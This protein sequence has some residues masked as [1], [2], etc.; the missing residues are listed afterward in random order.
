MRTPE[1][2]IA[3]P[4][5]NNAAIVMSAPVLKIAVSRAAPTM[6]PIGPIALTKEAPVPRILVGKDSPVK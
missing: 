3:T 2:K 1:S 5:L 6:P 4:P